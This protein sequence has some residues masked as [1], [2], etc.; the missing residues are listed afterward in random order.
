MQPP[1]THIS[2]VGPPATSDGAAACAVPEDK[3]R[4]RFFITC[5][6]T[7][8]QLQATVDAVYHELRVIR[9]AAA[10]PPVDQQVPDP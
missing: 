10:A 4:L 5:V 7:E 2:R 3:A 1:P 8:A 9:S 6:H